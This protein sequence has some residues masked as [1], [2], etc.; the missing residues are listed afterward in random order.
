VAYL[1]FKGLLVFLAVYFTVL[2]LR[3][4]TNDTAKILVFTYLIFSFPLIWFSISND[5]HVTFSVPIIFALNGI[6]LSLS[7]LLSQFQIY[8]RI[9]IFVFLSG[10]L[11][12]MGTT[13]PHVILYFFLLFVWIYYH[14]GD[15]PRKFQLI[16]FISVALVLTILLFSLISFAFF[17]NMNPMAELIGWT[18]RFLNDGSWSYWKSADLIWVNNALSLL[19]YP[20]SF[21][22][23]IIIQLF[24][25][26]YNLIISVNIKLLT[27]AALTLSA[28]LFYS[29]F[30][31]KSSMGLLELWFSNAMVFASLVQL[32]FVL[33]SSLYK[34][35][36]NIYV[37]L[38]LLLFPFIISQIQ[39]PYFKISEIY[40][41]ILIF[42]CF[43]GFSL[44]YL[45]ANTWFLGVSTLL[46]YLLIFILFVSHDY[47][48]QPGAS[49]IIG[50]IYSDVYKS[51]SEYKSDW[52]LSVESSSW[53]S[54]KI[55]PDA[56]VFTLL[57]NDTSKPIFIDGAYPDPIWS[58]AGMLF[59][60]N[61]AYTFF[62][63]SDKKLIRDSDIEILNNNNSVLVVIGTVDS[64]PTDPTI[65]GETSQN[66]FLKTCNQFSA[67]G[68]PVKFCIYDLFEKPQV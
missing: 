53:V 3:S 36:F 32:T 21:F 33:I 50:P 40:V 65:F 24:S 59:W 45:I 51:S 48:K 41:L 35:K 13:F 14:K 17:E 9:F 5:Y 25:R 47:R 38:V 43:I 67:T 31:S 66:I 64:F 7:P 60:G 6:F 4:L 68:Y 28:Y 11:A 49:N 34:K 1:F 16:L 63:D 23:I 44:K 22:L 62:P 61:P 10:S 57:I 52:L 54:S 27:I 58:S 42:M 37:S 2:G 15:I 55:K 56:R 39:F 29:Q 8:F 26:S 18:I 19:L 46:V 20:F 30:V 12:F